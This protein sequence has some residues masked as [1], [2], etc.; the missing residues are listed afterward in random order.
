MGSRTSTAVETFLFFT[1]GTIAFGAACESRLLDS[2]KDEDVND[3]EEEEV[4]DDEEEELDQ[5]AA[6][7]SSSSCTDVELVGIQSVSAL[8]G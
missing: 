4:P 7:I 3:D 1:T 8:Q 5:Y 6:L 2:A